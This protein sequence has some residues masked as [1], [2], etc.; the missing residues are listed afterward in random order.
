MTPLPVNGNTVQTAGNNIV[1][2]NSALN[3]TALTHGQ[4]L[5]FIKSKENIEVN[6]SPLQ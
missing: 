1:R 4:I 6:K 5:T 3:E 2:E